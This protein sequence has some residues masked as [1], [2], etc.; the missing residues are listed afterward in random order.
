MTFLVA[1]RRLIQ[2]PGAATLLRLV[3]C[4][5]AGL[6]LGLV[7]SGAWAFVSDRA[8]TG[9]ETFQL[10]IPPGTAA[11]VAR[12]EAATSLPSRIEL[13]SGDR[14]VVRNDD[15]VVHQLGFSFIEPGGAQEV[16]FAAA[17]QRTQFVCTFHVAGQIDL[18]VAAT[19]E[20]IP[21]F[22]ASLVVGLPLGVATF[23][24]TTIV[25]RL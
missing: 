15:S 5:A 25:S 18:D 6:A 21:L 22:L 16:P 3:L 12:G 2:A 11:R 7:L 8:Q 24:V 10:T 4:L 17:A 1:S 19:K 13:R 9:P 23:A 14:L 20:P